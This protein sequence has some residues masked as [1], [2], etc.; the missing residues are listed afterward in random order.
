MATG[1][2]IGRKISTKIDQDQACKGRFQMSKTWAFPEA[3]PTD[4]IS[5]NQGLKERTHGPILEGRLNSPILPALMASASLLGEARKE[6][7][8]NS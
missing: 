7:P 5:A 1:S 2:P 4:P 6:F 8:L 3:D